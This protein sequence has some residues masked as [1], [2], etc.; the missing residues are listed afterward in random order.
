[1][2]PTRHIPDALPG[3]FHEIIVPHLKRMVGKRV[4]HRKW[5]IHDL[6]PLGVLA[7]FFRGDNIIVL[8]RLIFLALLSI[9]NTVLVQLPV[10]LGNL[11]FEAVR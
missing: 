11:S 6:F 1:M 3:F 9:F 4:Q 10:C 7:G 5:H 8:F 2:K